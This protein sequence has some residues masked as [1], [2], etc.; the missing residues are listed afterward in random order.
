MMSGVVLY[1]RTLMLLT[2]VLSKKPYY[3]SAKRLSRGFYPNY[4]VDYFTIFTKYQTIFTIKR[5][6]KRIVR[7]FK[8][9][10]LLNE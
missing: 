9:N 1:S 5:E 8:I 3:E 6:T 7:E 10:N 2:I 4:F